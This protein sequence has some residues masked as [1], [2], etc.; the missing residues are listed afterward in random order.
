M[1]FYSDLDNTLIYSYK[2][3]IGEEKRCVEIYQGREVSFMT[4]RSYQLLQKVNEKSLFVPVTTR[5]VEQYRRID[6]G[7][8]APGYALACNG[9]IL[10]VD[11]QKDMDWYRE[12][13]EMA[14]GCQEELHKAQK[15]LE[16]DRDV[17]FEIRDIEQLFLFTKSA[18]PRQTDRKL[19]DALDPS[20]VDVFL[21]GK[22]VYV[23]PKILTK[24]NAVRR[25]QQRLWEESQGGAGALPGGY[26]GPQQGKDGIP[27]GTVAAGDSE[28]DIPMLLEADVALA[29]KEMQGRGIKKRRLFY[30]DHEKVFSD[31][32]L[33]YVD[34]AA[35]RER[36]RWP[37]CQ[38]IN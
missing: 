29:P 27:C 37:E 22:K 35:C 14:A 18:H 19:Q 31:F 38:F 12:S 21:N 20:L 1:V 33:H 2:H 28:F 15:L 4:E 9:G 25:F 23:V 7:I 24:G 16:K 11:G 13:R 8:C 5:T 30:M 10:L 3:D 26:T 17:D 36:I 34:E 32:V 6:F